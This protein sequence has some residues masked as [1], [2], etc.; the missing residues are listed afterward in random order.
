MQAIERTTRRPYAHA[1]SG[2]VA[3]ARARLL[4]FN[5]RYVSTPI[6][7]LVMAFVSAAC[8]GTDSN[9]RGRSLVRSGDVVVVNGRVLDMA[10]AGVVDRGF[11]VV[12]GE[13]IV[14]IS[15]GSIDPPSGVKVIDARGGTIMPGLIDAH[16]H[17]TATLIGS[18]GGNAST[19]GRLRPW[20]REGV[21][22]VL[23]VGSV[24]GSLPALKRRIEGDGV[25]APRVAWAGPILTTAGGY[26]K[27]VFP[28]S[29]VGQE[30][31]S[32]SEGRMWVSRLSQ[33]GATVVKLGLER[34]FG[35]DDSWP[36]M[37]LD[38]VTAIAEEAHRHGM[39]VTAHATS[40]DEVQL[41]LDGG[42]DNLAHTPTEP[43]PDSLLELMAS[44]KTAITSTLAI[45]PGSAAVANLKKFADLGG[46]VAAGTDFGCCQ[47]PPG[48]AP[49]IEELEIMRG[50]GFSPLDT[51]LAAT[52]GGAAVSNLGSRTGTLEPG[53]FADIIVVR[54]DPV[55]DVRA[56]ARADFV[57]KAG[58]VVIA[59]RT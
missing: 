54:G 27:P 47:Q 7:L 8:T 57:L 46:V 48:A 50:G 31:N 58:R 19:N 6:P 20:A 32:V 33:E 30:V 18:M 39:L 13:N 14:S 53:K 41:A 52:R 5:R 15:S 2:A 34:G 59:R 49:L 3:D 11:V 29:L 1:V 25:D 21:T 43:L 36:L 26:P 51:L 23:D 55:A 28:S 22:T 9:E 42:V 45:F 24:P 35:G 56:L 4:G 37:P 38:H 16:V 17:L 12:R 44:K 10:R 40:P